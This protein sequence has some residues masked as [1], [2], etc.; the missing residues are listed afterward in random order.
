MWHPMV[1]MDKKIGARMGENG[2]GARCGEDQGGVS[3]PF[4][5]WGGERRPVEGGQRRWLVVDFLGDGFEW[6]CG[7]GKGNG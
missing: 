4:I 2:G 6:R 7:A 5:G 3:A 1:L